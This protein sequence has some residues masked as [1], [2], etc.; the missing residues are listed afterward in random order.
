MKGRKQTK[1]EGGQS[2]TYLRLT[3]AS[4][5]PR[6]SVA[7]TFRD[8]TKRKCANCNEVGHPASF[9]GCK[10]Y[11]AALENFQKPKG[12]KKKPQTTLGRQF[13]SKKTTPGLSY[14]SMAERNRPTAPAERNN[15]NATNSN[16]PSAQSRLTAAV[17]QSRLFPNGSS[18]N[19]DQVVNAINPLINDLDSPIAKIMLLSKLVEMCFGCNV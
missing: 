12:N 13:T 2:G 10:S 9:H 7:K 11:I 1:M 6:V 16:A 17:A 15:S 8:E 4:S 19:V 18:T 14:S 3:R 5:G